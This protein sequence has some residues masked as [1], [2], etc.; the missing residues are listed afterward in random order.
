MFPDHD[1]PSYEDVKKWFTDYLDK[2][3]SHIKRTFSDGPYA[4]QWNG[5][6]NF[7][8]SVPT[9]WTWKNHRVVETYKQCIRNAGFGKGGKQHEFSIGLTEAEAAAIHTFRSEAMSIKVC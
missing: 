7:V 5:K 4:A 3:H 8:F 2:L 6:V 9:T 1:S